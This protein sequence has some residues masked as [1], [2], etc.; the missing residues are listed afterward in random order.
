MV[1]HTPMRPETAAVRGES[2]IRSATYPH[3]E[4]PAG[5][6]HIHIHTGRHRKTDTDRQTNRQHWTAIP[7]EVNCS[8]KTINVVYLI[9]CKK[10]GQ[11]YVGDPCK[12]CGQQYVGETGQALHYRMNIIEQTSFTKSSRSLHVIHHVIRKWAEMGGGEAS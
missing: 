1:C 4:S 3:S 11:Q 10:C 6:T 7:V 2:E 9:P 12:K 5:Q 8:C